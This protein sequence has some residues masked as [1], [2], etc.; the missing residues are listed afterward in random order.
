MELSSSTSPV[1]STESS[2]SGPSHDL[3]N[4]S[5]SEVEES[6]DL[7][8]VSLLSKLRAPRPSDLSRRRKIAANPPCGKR[9]SR[10]YGTDLKT[11]KPEKRVRENPNEPLTVSSG[12]LFCRACREELC[13]KSSSL[14]NHLS[15]TKHLEGKK[16]WIQKRHANRTFH[17]P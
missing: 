4:S 11:I 12:K 17:R 7:E 16:D 2:A 8:A 5:V 9:K 6:E 3:L 15:S 13:L 1:C 10:S 14:K